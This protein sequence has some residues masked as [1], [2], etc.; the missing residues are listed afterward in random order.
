MKKLAYIVIFSLF[1]T[2]SRGAEQSKHDSFEDFV[3]MVEN[4][5]SETFTYVISKD[6]SDIL[7]LSD[8][9]AIDLGKYDFIIIGGGVA[10]AVV[11]NRLSEVSDW[12]ILLV[13][14]G[15]SE[16]D[17]SKIPGLVTYT[18]YSTKNWGYNTTA[19][20]N[21]CLGFKNRQCFM[22]QGRVLGGGSAI[23]GVVN[24]RGHPTDFNRWVSI[25]GNE[26]WSYDEVLHY[27]KKSEKA[28]FK[29]VN[30]HYHGEDGYIDVSIP[31]VTPLLEPFLIKSFKNIGME[32]NDD[33]NGKKENGLSRIQYFIK[34]G[35]R[36]STA[37]AFLD[38]LTSRRNLHITSDSFV[39]KIII[40]N[41]TKI[42]EGIHFVKNGKNYYAT[43]SK[44]VIVSAGAINSPQ[45]LMLSGIGP[46]RHLRNLN[47]PVIQD[48]PV[49]EYL[50][51]HVM[52][53][54]LIIRTSKVFYNESLVDYLKLYT[55]NK[56]PLNAFFEMLGF[57]TLGPNKL[58]R[59]DIEYLMGLPIH[60][61]KHKGTYESLNQQYASA[62]QL[63]SS[64][65]I[66]VM[67]ILLHPKSRGS[68]TLKSNSPLDK[69]LIDTNYLAEDDDVEILYQGVKKILD[70]N[71]T[72][73]FRNFGAYVVPFDYPNCEENK[74]L[75]KEWWICAIKHMSS[76]ICY[77]DKFLYLP[78]S[79]YN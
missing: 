55:E 58:I 52:F 75:S 35:K 4:N 10:G 39:T 30:R 63:N 46:R 34:D 29:H 44:E 21:A 59:P 32:F 51:D 36:V 1:Y 45:V 26:G 69:P 20:K 9:K 50:Q 65:D 38:K 22:P 56:R 25:Y 37:S 27:I 77:V 43:A 7:T 18:F 14:A 16:N 15:G 54:G 12:N 48:L 79:I 40:N 3:T 2:T 67:P 61:S 23:N 19:Q 31:Q 28:V 73:E 60:T 53:T 70:L 72:K 71:N 47:I 42:A 62:F 64:S 6:N 8:T 33:Y 5:I 74:K 49:G 78:S 41:T 17:F 66:I 76:T 13:E 11:A 24:S 57:I 68:V